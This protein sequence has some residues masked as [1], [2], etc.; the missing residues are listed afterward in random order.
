MIY[1]IIE[2]SITL[3]QRIKNIY[4]TCAPSEQEYL[5]KIL[6]EL[7]RSG[8]STTYDNLWLQDYI[9]IPVDLDTFL[10]D[11]RYLGRTNQNG[12]SVYPF[13]KQSMHDIFD[14]GNQYNQCVFTGATRI[15]KTSTAIT[16]SCYMLYKMM[17]S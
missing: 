5:I 7:S 6:E 17:W 15:G 14:A 16:C 12:N 4:K 13:W 1:M 11:D 8:T 2:D 3:P 9:E 10:C